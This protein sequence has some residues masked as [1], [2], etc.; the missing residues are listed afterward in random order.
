[1]NNL[2]LRHLDKCDISQV[3]K[4]VGTARIYRFIYQQT[5][6]MLCTS[7][8]IGVVEIETERGEKRYRGKRGEKEV[9]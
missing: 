6:K 3:L 7:L 4:S 5:C 8:D 9:T 1:M 2:K